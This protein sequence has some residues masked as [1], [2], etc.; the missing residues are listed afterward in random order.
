[1]SFQ[2][3][4]IDNLALLC[5]VFM[6]LCL[7]RDRFVRHKQVHR[8][9]CEQN[10]TVSWFSWY[11]VIGEECSKWCEYEAWEFAKNR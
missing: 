1:M 7:L 5:I 8:E 2:Y 6:V 10:W 4:L 9:V 3:E 11:L